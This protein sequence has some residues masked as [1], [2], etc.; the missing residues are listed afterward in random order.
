MQDFMSDMGGILGLY[1]G[2]S[3][4]T[5]IEFVELFIDLTR[6]GLMKLCC[7]KKPNKV[8]DLDNKV[9]PLESKTAWENPQDLPMTSNPANLSYLD[10]KQDMATFQ[11]AIDKN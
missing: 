5:I 3:I 10:I 9:A 1:I 11:K 8:D 7:K 4:L 6:L 2:F